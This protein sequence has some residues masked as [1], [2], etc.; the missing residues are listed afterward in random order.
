MNALIDT[1][2]HLDDDYAE[3]DVASLVEA[4]RQA[5]IIHLITIG[6]NLDATARIQVISE[7]YPEVFHSLGIH[8]QSASADEHRDWSPFIQGLTHPKCRALGEIGLDY[9][10]GGDT[11][12]AQRRVLRRQLQLAIHQAQP[13]L[14][15]SREAER[16]LLEEL[17]RYVQELHQLRPEAI[18]GIIHCFSGTQAF[19]ES[20]LELGFYLSF[21]GILTFPKAQALRE[22]AQAF[23]LSRL[24]VET[25]SPYLAP[26]PHRGKKCEPA[27]V[28]FTAEKLAQVK[29]LSVDEV[30]RVTTQNAQR[31][32]KIL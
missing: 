27:W 4:A 19:G 28:R 18:P 22:A 17:T 21:S 11:T 23:P 3:R 29:D 25:D 24:V 6:T 14:I 13:V 8:P 12:G 20:C 10:R 31:I 9:Y 16:D 1:H 2:C 26:L 5:E 30:C 32:F 7:T 15:H